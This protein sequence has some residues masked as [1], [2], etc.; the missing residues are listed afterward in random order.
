MEPGFEVQ[1][2]RDSIVKLPIRCR[3]FHHICHWTVELFIVEMTFV[4]E[5][6]T[7]FFFD[8]ENFADDLWCR[9]F[10]VTAVAVCIKKK[11]YLRLTKFWSNTPTTWTWEMAGGPVIRCWLDMSLNSCDHDKNWRVVLSTWTLLLW[12]MIEEVKKAVEDVSQVK[13]ET[14]TGGDPLGYYCPTQRVLNCSLIA[15]AAQSC[16]W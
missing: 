8:L 12:G 1:T 7:P 16:I 14:D 2:E 6:E 5:N 11:Q 3:M 4:F 9:P 13:D 15:P 10:A